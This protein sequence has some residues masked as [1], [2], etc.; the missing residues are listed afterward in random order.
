V[1]YETLLKNKRAILGTIVFEALLGE[2][3]VA[4]GCNEM[5]GNM[6]VEYEAVKQED[7]ELEGALLFFKTYNF[8]S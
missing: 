2:M 3:G 8:N 4:L 6:M 7:L 5:V 1:L